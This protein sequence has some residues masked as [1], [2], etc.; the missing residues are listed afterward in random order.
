MNS[1]GV[2]YFSAFARILGNCVEDSPSISGSGN[3]SYSWSPQ[4]EWH[5]WQP[6]LIQQMATSARCIVCNKD[7]LPL[8]TLFEKGCSALNRRSNKYNDFLR[9]VPGDEIHSETKPWILCW[10]VMIQICWSYSVIMEILH[11]TNCSSNPNQKWM[12][13]KC[14]CG[15]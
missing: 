8:S 9:T 12:Q 13:K 3:K 14:A 7:H 4:I 5:R 6:S 11:H 10:L 15:T 2:V 1:S